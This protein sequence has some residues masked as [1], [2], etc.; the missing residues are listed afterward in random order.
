MP[1]IIAASAADYRAA[2]GRRLLHRPVRIQGLQDENRL[3]GDIPK[4]QVREPLSVPKRIGFRFPGQM[5]IPFTD[6]GRPGFRG[7]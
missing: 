2:V 6:L 1:A 4:S 5:G 7:R 3:W